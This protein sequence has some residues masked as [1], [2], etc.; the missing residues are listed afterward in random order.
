MI[1]L[2]FEH[3][4][5]REF[6]TGRAPPWP[7]SPQVGVGWAYV[8]GAAV[9]LAGAAIALA[10]HARLAAICLGALIFCWALLRHVP[11]VA[12]SEILSPDWTRAVKALAFCG[13]ALVMAA[14]FPDVHT[15]QSTRF[16]RLVNARRGFINIGTICLAVFMVNNG[17]QHFIY[18]GFV[19]SLIPT[20]FPGDGVFWTYAA[21]MLLFCGALGML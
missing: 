2:G 1:G 15:S 13:G 19:A 6:V 14:T 11:V 4:I 3:F 16:S 18:T 20:W 9:I 8:S 21:A 12:V 5:Y 17:M 7:Y 10:R